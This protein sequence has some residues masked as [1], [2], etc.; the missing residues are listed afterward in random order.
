ML[1]HEAWYEEDWQVIDNE[2]KEGETAEGKKR[3]EKG[4]QEGIREAKERIGEGHKNNEC[5]GEELE[6]RAE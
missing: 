5:T 6:K 3:L 2:D 4:R 1:A